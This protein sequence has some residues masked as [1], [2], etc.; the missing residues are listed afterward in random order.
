MDVAGGRTAAGRRRLVQLCHQRA[1]LGHT[2]RVGGAQDQRV[3]ARLGNQR[4]LERG[5]RLP[6]CG[7][8]RGTAAPVDQARHQRREV[9]GDGVAQ[10][11]H[12]HIAGVGD[13]HGRHDARQA[14]QVVRVIGD[15]QRVV[16]GVHVDGVV[17][18][19][20]R[21]QHGHQIG[22]V[23]KVELEDLG[24][25]LTATGRAA[26]AAL[27]HAHA[28]ALQLG[29]GLGHHLV[30]ACSLHHRKA[31]QPQRGQELLEGGGGR[32][33]AFGDQVELAL[34]ARVDHH[35]AARDGGHGAGHGFDLGVGEVQGDGLAGAH[36]AGAGI[37]GGLGNNLAAGARQ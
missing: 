36:A 17:G 22:G 14:L 1:H 34:H 18:A 35:V 12:F 16:A 10:R 31:L 13:I 26:R 15:H 3:A 32:H 25:D 29:V 6:L 7:D 24:D 4:G 20:Q 37:N 11:D 23:F 30:Q 27:H 2:G 9:S 8:R 33:G 19:D 28:A 5:V 21:A